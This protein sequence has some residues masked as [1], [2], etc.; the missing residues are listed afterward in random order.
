MGPI[1][2]TPNDSPEQTSDSNIGEGHGRDASVFQAVAH[3]GFQRG[4]PENTLLAYRIAVAL[5]AKFVETDI[6]LTADRVPI[7]F[8]DDTL[9]RVCGV[10]GRVDNMTWDELQRLSAHEPARFGNQFKDQPITKLEQFCDWLT[11]NPDVTAFVELKPEAVERTGDD[12]LLDVVL[13]LLARVSSQIVVISFSA[14]VLGKLREHGSR[15]PIG[16]VTGE[17][18]ETDIAVALNADYVFCDVDGLPPDGDL[19]VAGAKLAVYEVPDCSQAIQ[20]AKRGVQF[21]ESFDV[22]GLITD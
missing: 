10:S 5:G 3:R 6:Q 8:H 21:V 15:L 2:V 20:L 16:F 17:W 12:A 4:C 22:A 1:A 7:L 19:Q 14:S 18:S 11:A 13:P 9:D